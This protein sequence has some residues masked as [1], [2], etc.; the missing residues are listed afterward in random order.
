MAG[1]W[2]YCFYVRFYLSEQRDVVKHSALQVTP[3]R[4]IMKK[5][6]KIKRKF[7]PF[8]RLEKFIMKSLE[9]LLAAIATI[10]R[11]DTGDAD[12]ATQVAE[13]KAQM[14]EANARLVANEANDEESK[15]I[16]ADQQTL[17]EALI[18]QLAAAPAP[19]PTPEV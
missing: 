1:C 4:I 11:G 8:K 2:L 17:I 12:V 14:L 5:R 9:E 7:S 13:L 16:N 19:A 3:D 15:K 18:A 10:A 6:C